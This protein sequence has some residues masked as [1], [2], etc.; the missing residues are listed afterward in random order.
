M[1]ILS[2]LAEH[3]PPST[4]PSLYALVYSLLSPCRCSP[5][6]HS[7]QRRQLRRYPL[8]WCSGFCLLRVWE[9]SSH[10]SHGT[11]A[12]A[13]RGLKNW[14][15]GYYCCCW[16]S[17]SMQLYAWVSW[18]AGIRKKEMG[19]DWGKGINVNR[20]VNRIS[21]SHG[22]VSVQHKANIQQCNWSNSLGG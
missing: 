18:V 19:G 6:L 21:G 11:A 17:P 13:G 22:E 16:M 2:L 7:F 1:I 4:P 9:M 20:W 12:A 14:G 8:L 3:S 10:V 15:W 5:P